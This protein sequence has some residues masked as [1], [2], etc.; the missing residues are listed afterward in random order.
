MHYFINTADMRVDVTTRTVLRLRA[1]RCLSKIWLYA[2]TTEYPVVPA[3]WSEMLGDNPSGAVNQ[4]E[5]LMFRIRILR[6]Y[7]P[8]IG[9]LSMKI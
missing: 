7:T 5:R 8:N 6:D 4:Q 3:S 2:G 1:Q 9:I